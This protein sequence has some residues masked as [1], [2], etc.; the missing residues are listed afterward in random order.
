MQDIF[1]VNILGRLME[2]REHEELSLH[3]FVTILSLVLP[4]IISQQRVWPQIE[5][6]GMGP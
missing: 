6:K 2:I 4:I 1:K 5:S 3:Y